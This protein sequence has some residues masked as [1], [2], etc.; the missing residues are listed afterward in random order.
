MRFASSLFRCFF[1]LVFALICSPAFTSDVRWGID[2]Q[3]GSASNLSL[4]LSLEQ[5]TYKKSIT[6]DYSTRPWGPG[7]APYYNIRFRRYS[8]SSFW[9]FELLHHKLFLDNK[10]PEVQEF[11]LTFGY[12]LLPISWGT[13][14]YFDWLR[15]YVGAGPIVAHPI[16]TVNGKTLPNEPKLW[17]TG[18]RYSLIG[19]GIQSGLEAYYELN[20]TFYVNADLRLSASKSRVPLVDGK[21]SLNQASL[22]YQAGLGATW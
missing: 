4:P 12:N 15:A 10:P 19:F 9:S 13:R 17:P 16:N 6:A 21:A 14:F 11:R 7:A 20:S 3:T 2:I 8:E 22:H 18:E 5:G 1:I